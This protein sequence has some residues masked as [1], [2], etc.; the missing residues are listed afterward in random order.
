MPFVSFTTYS[1]AIAHFYKNFVKAHTGI[2]LRTKRNKRDNIYNI[3]LLKETAISIINLI[4]TENCISLKRKYES[5]KE[6]VKWCRP[7]HWRARTI[8]I[9]WTEDQDDFILKHT[10]ME[11]M[12]FLKRS[13]QSIKMRLLRLTNDRNER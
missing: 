2:I 13:K 7:D 5:A 3:V 9:P 6:A 12:N 8:Q 4:Y 11:S 1:D 10:I